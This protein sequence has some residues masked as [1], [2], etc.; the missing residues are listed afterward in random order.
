[1][2]RCSR[3]DSRTV[4]LLIE[5]DPGDQELARRAL[6]DDAIKTDLHVASD[7]EEAMNYLLR[8]GSYTNPLQ[9]PRPHLILLDLNM[10]R[11]GGREVLSQIRT[12]PEL[13]TIPVVILSTSRDDRDVEISYRLG[14]NSFMTKPTDLDTFIDRVHQL[15]TYWFG[16]VRL[17]TKGVPPRCPASE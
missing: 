7:G 10:P 8:Q 3:D 15:M 12:H 17:P 14:C 4:V 13:Q 6:D 11:M 5:D 16:L 2:G 9:S 1:M